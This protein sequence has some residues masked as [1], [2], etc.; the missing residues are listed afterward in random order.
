[1]NDLI[2]LMTGPGSTPEGGA[3]RTGLSVVPKFTKPHE[4]RMGLNPK[5]PNPKNPKNP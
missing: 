1:M 3:I 5:T 2:I 4:E